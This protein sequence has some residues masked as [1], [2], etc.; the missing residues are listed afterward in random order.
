MSLFKTNSKTIRH[1]KKPT[2]AKIIQLEEHVQKTLGIGQMEQA[3]LL[4]PGEDLN[5][6]L[7]VHCYD[8]M[9]EIQLLFGS[10]EEGCTAETCPV[11]S[12]GPNFEY[13]W[14]EGKELVSLTAIDYINKCLAYIQDELDDETVFPC[15]PGVP[16]PK[17]FKKVVMMIFKR[18]FRIYAHIYLHHITQISQLEEEPHLNSSFKACPPRLTRS[19]SSSSPRS[20]ASWRRRRSSRCSASSSSSRRSWRRSINER[21]N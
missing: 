5:E 2:N 8:F 18:L 4:P 14:K 11:M 13:R 9:K 16:F 15:E 6:W 7:A 19:T 12:A 10:I 17:N 1:I 20:S 3:V 21:Y